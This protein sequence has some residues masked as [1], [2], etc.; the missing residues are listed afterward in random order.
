MLV[1]TISTRPIIRN[2]TPPAPPQEEAP[3]RVKDV[4]CKIGGGL[5]A[6]VGAGTYLMAGPLRALGASAQDS[7]IFSN[8]LTAATTCGLVGAA[9]SGIA[10]LAIGLPVG[11]MV[12]MVPA[13]VVEELHKDRGPLFSEM[14]GVLDERLGLSEGRAERLKEGLVHGAREGA[15]EAYRYGYD[16]TLRMLG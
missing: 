15:K 2:A 7:E 10:G 14:Q 3:G 11:A 6:T 12:G 16:R 8:V 5:T 13:L 1:Q 4:L 9:F